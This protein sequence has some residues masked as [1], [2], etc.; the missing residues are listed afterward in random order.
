MLRITQ[1]A[2][3][4][5]L[6]RGKHQIYLYTQK[7]GCADY[8]Y[9]FTFDTE[10]C[11]DPVIIDF[12]KV[13]VVVDKKDLEL[14]DHVEIDHKTSLV[15]EKFTVNLDETVIRCGCGISFKK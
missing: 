14:V 8:K 11:D 2:I 15:S 9:C 5:I 3:A 4:K 12:D 10:K 6:E 1:K 7:G 13:Q